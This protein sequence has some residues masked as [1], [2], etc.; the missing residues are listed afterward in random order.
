MNDPFLQ[1]LGLVK[2]SG[3][4]IEGYN[5]CLEKI[6]NT[7]VYLCIMSESVSQNTV[8]KFT[9]ICESKNVRLLRC[10]TGFDLGKALGN[11]EINILCILD[12]SVSEKLI[13]IYD[14]NQNNRG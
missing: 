4:M 1:F 10:Y 3:K 2:K 9:R 5:S 7:H 14:S 13:E 12:K 11:E 6:Q 8:K